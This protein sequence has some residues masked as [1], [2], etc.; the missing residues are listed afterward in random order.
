MAVDPLTPIVVGVGQCVDHWD[1]SDASQAP[2]P[3]GLLSLAGKRAVQDTDAAAEVLAS[4]DQV[5]VVRWFADSMPGTPPFGSCENPPASLAADIGAKGAQHFYSVVGDDQPQKLMNVA[6]GV[7][8][9][10]TKEDWQPISSDALQAQIDETQL[11]PGLSESA[12]ADIESLSVTYKRGDPS[13]AVVIVQCDKGRI[14]ARA[15]SGDVATMKALDRP[16]AIGSRVT[17]V[18][19]NGR[20]FIA[21]SA[22]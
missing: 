22:G 3:R 14:V 19:E 12:D 13:H 11:A 2:S 4:I 6:A 15:R 20:N 21:A 18:H 16:D 1:G 5:H 8:S 7:Y 9:A 10:R 17:V